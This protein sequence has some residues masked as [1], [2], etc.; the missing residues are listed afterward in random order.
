VQGSGFLST[1]SLALKK[2]KKSDSFWFTVL[3]AGKSKIWQLNPARVLCC[4]LAEEQK[5][6]WMSARKHVW[7]R[8]KGSARL[9]L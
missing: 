3:E 1:E 5:R 7:K 6:E 4:L 2:K 8:V 9:T